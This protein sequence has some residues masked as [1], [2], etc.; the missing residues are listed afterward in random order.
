[1]KFDNMKGPMAGEGNGND[2]PVVESSFKTIKLKHVGQIGFQTR[3]QTSVRIGNAIDA[4]YSTVRWHSTIGYPLSPIQI[5][6]LANSLKWGSTLAK[7][8]QLSKNLFLQTVKGLLLTCK[9]KK[10]HPATASARQ[11]SQ[12]STSALM[13]AQNRPLLNIT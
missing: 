3:T 9:I 8:G 13:R 1:M 11:K 4:F 2:H 6:R 7:Q 10:N 12:L 5:E